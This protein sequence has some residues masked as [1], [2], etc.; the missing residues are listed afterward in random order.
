[1]KR[2]IANTILLIL[3]FTLAWAAVSPAAAERTNQ[4]LIDLELQQL[5]RHFDLEA[6]AP[7]R[8]LKPL[9]QVAENI[10]IITAD[11]IERMNAHTLAEVL[12]RVPGLFINFGGADFGSPSLILMEGADERHA[13][14]LLDGIDFNHLSGGNALT[15]P[16]PVQIIDRIEIILGPASSAWGSSLG[17]VVSITTKKGS[18]ADGRPKGLI[19]GSYGSG[20]SQDYRAEI[21]GQ[22]RVGYYLYAGGMF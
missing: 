22:D 16:I 17:G 9:S 21:S 2:G 18:D 1:M 20:N 6:Q 13:K 15:L 5:S 19:Q 11:D 12:N 14:I 4:E 7:T 10:T 3:L 8:V